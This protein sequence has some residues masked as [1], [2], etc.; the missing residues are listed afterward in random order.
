MDTSES[1][2]LYK[3]LI[4]SNQPSYKC[5]TTHQLTELH[6]QEEGDALTALPQTLEDVGMFKAPASLND[7]TESNTCN[8]LFVCQDVCFI[9]CNTVS[10]G[11]SLSTQFTRRAVNLAVIVDRCNA[12]WT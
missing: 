9:M 5:G 8:R 10:L 6:N 4:F 7:K 11:P 2:A 1:T 3:G 12:S